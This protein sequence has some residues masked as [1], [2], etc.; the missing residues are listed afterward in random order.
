MPLYEYIENGKQV[1][2]RLPVA[3]RDDFPGR[4]RVPSRVNVCPRGEPEHGSQLMQ[5]W[6]ECEESMGTEGVRSMARGLGLTREQVKQACAAPDSVMERPVAG[7]V[8]AAG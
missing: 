8:I 1:I 3:R 7:E 2:R 5:G 4:V 6:K